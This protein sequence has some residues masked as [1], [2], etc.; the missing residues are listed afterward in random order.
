MMKIPKKY[1]DLEALVNNK[2]RSAEEEGL[3]QGLRQEL[4]T[5]A[6]TA[7]GYRVVDAEPEVDCDLEGD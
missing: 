4:A 7:L 5:L 3:Y 2:R 6:I 1:A